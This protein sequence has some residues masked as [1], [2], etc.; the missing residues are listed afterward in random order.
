MPDFIWL[1]EAICRWPRLPEPPAGDWSAA[2]QQRLWDALVLW[3]QVPEHVGPRDIVGLVRQVLRREEVRERSQASLEVPTVAPWPTRGAWEEAGCRVTELGNDRRLVAARPWQPDWLPGAASEPPEE[4]AFGEQVR[5]ESSPLP[6]DGFLSVIGFEH[7]SAPGQRQALR[8]VLAS[9]PGATILVNLPTGTGKSAVAHVPA[10]LWGPPAG[11]TVV[12]VPTTALA[13]DQERAVRSYSTAEESFTAPLAYHDGLTAG[14]R[15]AVRAAIREGTQRLLFSS[16]ESI[17]GALAPA[18]FHAARAG[19]LRLF[20]LDEA[21]LVSQWGA[22]FRPEFQAIAGVRR[23]LLR[24]ACDAGAEAFRTLLLTATLTEDSLSVLYTLFGAP[25]PFEHVSAVTLRA[26]PSYW[27]AQCSDEAQRRQRLLEVVANLPRPLVVYVGT[28]AQVFEY[29]S[30]LR[31]H[32]YRRVADISGATSA[33]DRMSVIRG[34]RGE[35][36]DV[37]GDLRTRLDVV[38]ATSA[39][40]LGVDQAD[41]RAVV[42]ACIPE[43]IDRFYQEV[44]RGGR[45]GLACLSVVLWTTDDKRVARALNR[46]RIIGTGRGFDR[47]TAMLCDRVVIDKARGLFRMPLDA[48]PPHVTLESDENRAWNLRTLALMARAGLIELDAEPPPRRSADEPEEAWVARCAATFARYRN[49]SV[50]RLL[51]QRA[52]ERSVW[53]ERCRVVRQQ[54]RDFDRRQLDAIR[55][56][57]VGEPAVCEVLQAAYEIEWGRGESGPDIVIRPE[58][59]CGGCPA[60]RARARQPWEGVRPN[61]PPLRHPLVWVAPPLQA[62][63]AGASTLWAF[64]SPNCE[65]A[66]WRRDVVRLVERAVRHGVRNIVAPPDVLADRAVRRCFRNAPGRAVFLNEPDDGLSLPELPTLWLQPNAARVRIPKEVLERGGTNRL[67]IV[68]ASEDALDP[69]H[70][71]AAASQMRTPRLPLAKLLERL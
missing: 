37:H 47:W 28:T 58:R 36:P 13:L 43:T 11:L 55:G 40:G 2:C 46:R 12:V 18:L 44:G 3:A 68:V 67:W 54:A 26:E 4:A 39:F 59:S 38:V 14:E 21:H 42:H 61:P 9:Q 35:T 5:R 30:L 31:Q 52:D 65:D 71:T 34:W 48:R 45:D 41:V 69:E 57:L 60:C 22:E 62:V 66:S 33:A 20:V 50:I 51:D 70:P 6:G 17:V 64:A 1:A 56:L 32:G 7:Y 16:P 8:A 10:L 25:G 24:A 27:L 19:S 15:E 53:D 29:A 49:T 23:A 63:L